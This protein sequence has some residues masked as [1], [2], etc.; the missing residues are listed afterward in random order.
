MLFTYCILLTQKST[1]KIWYYFFTNP[2]LLC[3]FFSKNSLFVFFFVGQSFLLKSTFAN[4]TLRLTCREVSNS[5]KR[6]IRHYS[7]VFFFPY[8]TTG[9]SQ[10]RTLSGINLIWIRHSSCF[11]T[12]P[13]GIGEFVLISTRDKLLDDTFSVNWSQFSALNF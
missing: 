12:L 3:G 8:F 4:N 10:L 9:T 6:Q 5:K 11:I 2:L 7:L 1:N 13:D